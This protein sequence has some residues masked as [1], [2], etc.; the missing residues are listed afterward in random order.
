MLSTPSSQK[1]HSQSFLFFPYQ[2]KSKQLK[3]TIQAPLPVDVR[4][5]TVCHVE[6][7]Q[8][9]KQ[10]A[11]R[12]VVPEMLAHG[13][14]RR[15]HC[16]RRRSSSSILPPAGEKTSQER[17]L[18]F[19]ETLGVSVVWKILVRRACAVR[20]RRAAIV[21]LLL[22]LLLLLLFGSHPFLP[23]PP[24]PTTSKPVSLSFFVIY[25]YIFP[26]SLSQPLGRQ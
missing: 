20:T 25:I 2:N 19:L 24:F 8:G 7:V 10:L 16:R 22:L 23:R 6:I 12:V 3:L 9:P 11:P 15:R 5:P 21:P 1:V 26:L 4:Q 18:G 13:R 14:R 17:L